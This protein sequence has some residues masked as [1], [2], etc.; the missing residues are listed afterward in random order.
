MKPCP[1]LVPRSAIQG[2]SWP[3]VPDSKAATLLAMQQQLEHSQWWSAEQL[4]SAQLRQLE[5][6]LTH[7]G[8]HTPF[9]GERLQGLLPPA[10]QLTA[11]AWQQIP[12]LTR[13]DIQSAGDALRSNQLPT[14][15]GKPAKVQ[16][17][18]STGMPITAYSS[19]L[20]RFFWRVFTLREHHWHQRD[21]SATLAAIRPENK[22][23]PGQPVQL[24]GWGPATDLVYQTGPSFVLNSRTDIQTQAAWLQQL[25]PDY[26]LSLPS[27]LI[28]LARHCRDHGVIMPKLRQVRTFGEVASAEVRSLSR[29]VWGVAVKDIYS[30][31][32]VG[33]MATQCPAHEHYH[34]QS[35]GVYLEVLKE[36][37]S[38]CGPGEV[39]RVVVT[40]LHNYAYPLIRYALGDYAEV[41]TPCPCGRG[42]PV[43]TRI[44]GRERNMVVLPDGRKH[45]PSFPSELWD[46]IAPIRQLQLVQRDLH[47]IDAR[48]VTE[49]PLVAAEEG[50]FVEMLQQRFGYPFD[51]QLVYCEVIERSRGGKYE[52]FVS[53]VAG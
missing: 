42:L 32:E 14:S 53:M 10:G 39:G 3:A 15:H 13:S 34:V 11:E 23:S 45:Y 51:I 28:E 7:A 44:L 8:Q 22:Q 38:A 29:A 47:N 43:L 40:P 17:S 48:L 18:G 26:L 19:E 49:R 33:Y 30:S 4:L 16:T 5:Q 37:G 41:G 9:N 12:I 20:S 25:N 24:A 6:L 27:N 31:T 1:P 35:E 50:K 2:V 36:D 46:S 21:L 52:D